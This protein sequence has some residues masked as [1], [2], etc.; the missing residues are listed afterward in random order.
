MSIRLRRIWIPFLYCLAVACLVEIPMMQTEIFGEDRILW[1]TL[2]RTMIAIP[3]LWYFYK[4]DRM[5]RRAPHWN[6]KLAVILMAAG[7]AA[8]VG[9]RLIFELVGTM[10]YKEAEQNLLTGNLWLQALVL[11]GASPVLEEFLFRGVFY[12]RL[13]E[14]FSVRTAMVLSALGFGLYHANLSQ[15]IYGFFM[16]L[17]LAWSMEHCQTVKAPIVVHIA[18]NFAAIAINL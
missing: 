11:L 18:A 9:F 14:L 13:K 10:D 5:F 7:A 8:S 4:E 16:G 15:G 17:F 2:F 6:W 3:G 12:G 1:D